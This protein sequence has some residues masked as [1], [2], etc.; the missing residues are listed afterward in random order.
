[1]ADQVKDETLEDR[2]PRDPHHRLRQLIGE[3]PETRA[4][5]A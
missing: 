3:R 4:R 1:V 2:S 5:C